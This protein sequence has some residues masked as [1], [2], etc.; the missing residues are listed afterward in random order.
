MLAELKTLHFGASTYPSRDMARCAAVSARAAGLTV[1][2]V[3]KAKKVDQFFCGT[4]PGDT[5]PVE[6]RLC[7]HGPVRGLVFGS[8]AD[9]HKLLASIT[10][11]EA[12]A[13]SI[14]MQ[15]T[16]EAEA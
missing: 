1:K 2:Y 5:G 8:F 4:I 3:R 12:T 10:E 13:H 6:T 16:S 9:V 15:A 7:M 14:Q 11:A